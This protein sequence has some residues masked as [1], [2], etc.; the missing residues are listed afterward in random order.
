MGSQSMVYNLVPNC[1]I[2]SKKFISETVVP[3]I[4]NSVIPK[5]SKRNQNQSLLT[6][7]TWTSQT[8]QCYVM[9]AAYYI[10][11]DWSLFSHVLH[12]EVMKS[13]TW[14][15]IVELLCNIATKWKTSEKDA[16]LF[17][18]NA[19]NMVVA[20]Q[21]AGFLHIKYYAYTLN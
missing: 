6:S 13:L 19:S 12:T 14:T 1:F 11:K 10:T 16:T 9:F 5:K 4:Y 2:L 17:T 15:N 21:L 18:D 20:A 7:D 3:Q 8:T